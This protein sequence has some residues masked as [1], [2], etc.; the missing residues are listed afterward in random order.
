MLAEDNNYIHIRILTVLY[1]MNKLTT[2]E[3]IY[4]VLANTNIFL[5]IRHTVYVAPN[6]ILDIHFWTPQICFL[7][8]NQLK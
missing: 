4:N 2:F 6:L 5:E 1:K 7:C 8:F 3:L